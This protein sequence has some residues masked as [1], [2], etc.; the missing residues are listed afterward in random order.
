GLAA[1]VELFKRGNPVSDPDT[2]ASGV[3]LPSARTVDVRGPAPGVDADAIARTAPS[4]WAVSDPERARRGDPPS[5]AK[6]DVQGA[7]PVAVI[8]EVGPGNGDGRRRG[9]LVVVG[10]A[11]FA[12]DA[13]IDVLGNRDLALNA[14]AWTGGEELLAGTRAKRTAEVIRPLSPLVLTETQARA[15]FLAGVV[16]EPGLVLLVGLG[17]VA[18]RRRRG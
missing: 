2:L 13:Y 6:H 9:R 7:A 8:A 3:I 11:D 5:A 15:V 1:V 18:L 12:S 16:A 4:A 10:D 14:V 17:V